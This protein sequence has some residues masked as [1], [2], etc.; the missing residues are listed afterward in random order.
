M[1]APSKRPRTDTGD[2]RLRC[3]GDW[4][5]WS[6]ESHCDS[7][8]YA[9]SGRTVR[10]S[11]FVQ[12]SAGTHNKDTITARLHSCP[13]RCEGSDDAAATGTAI[14]AAAKGGGGVVVADPGPAGRHVYRGDPTTPALQLEGVVKT[15]LRGDEQVH[16][17][18]D[19]DFTLDAGEFVVVTGPS[20]AGKS[21]LL[22]IA[23]GHSSAL[24][25]VLP[26]ISMRE[27]RS[28][29][30]RPRAARPAESAGGVDAINTFAASAGHF[31]SLRV[32]SRSQ[33]QRFR[34]SALFLRLVRFPAAPHKTAGHKREIADHLSHA[35]I[36]V[37]IPVG[38]RS[39]APRYNPRAATCRPR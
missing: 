33:F 25:G 14:E 34:S 3:Q 4:R 28:V 17:L 37:K 19:F 27:S 38:R 30:P 35:K 13:R 22:H 1:M 11:G 26:T 5:P 18:V 29:M 15:Y 16:V 36:C 32:V 20:G 21:T 7:A 6:G 8:Q 24:V 23:G 2:R 39:S 9:H 10:A 12:R 31:A